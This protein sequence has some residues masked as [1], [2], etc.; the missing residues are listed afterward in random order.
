ML[1][2]LSCRLEMLLV[3]LCLPWRRMQAA[4]QVQAPGSSR[5]R[6]VSAGL[7]CKKP[8]VRRLKQRFVVLLLCLGKKEVRWSTAQWSWLGCSSLVLIMTF[9]SASSCR[10][11]PAPSLA[12]RLHD[13]VLVLQWEY[14]GCVRE[15]ITVMGVPSL[16]SRCC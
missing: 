16:G 10:S 4:A 1:P 5:T 7:C 3:G 11:V 2:V 6:A 15:D 8:L 13:L 12:C 14:D 9:T